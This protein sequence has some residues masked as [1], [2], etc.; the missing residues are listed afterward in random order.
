MIILLIVISK[1]LVQFASDFGMGLRFEDLI[2]FDKRR[3]AKLKS[4]AGNN[5]DAWRSISN[6]T[7]YKAIREGVPVESVQH[8]KSK[9]TIIVMNCVVAERRLV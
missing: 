7:L 9:S 3:N 1:E 6:F 8:K 4:D 2:E 5:R